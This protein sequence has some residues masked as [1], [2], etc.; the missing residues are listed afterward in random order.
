MRTTAQPLSNPKCTCCAKSA[1]R[2]RGPRSFISALR[3]MLVGHA[4][5]PCFLPRALPPWLASVCPLVFP[6]CPTCMACAT[7]A[8]LLRPATSVTAS[9]II[10]S[11]PE[12]QLTSWQNPSVGA[13][14]VT[15]CGFIR[16]TS[17]P[18]SVGWNRSSVSP[19]R[20]GRTRNN[21][22]VPTLVSTSLAIS[23]VH[24]LFIS[25]LP[26][27]SNSLPS[28]F[29]GPGG[30]RLWVVWGFLFPLRFDSGG[31]CPGPNCLGRAC[32]GSAL[33]PQVTDPPGKGVLKGTMA[34]WGWFP[35]CR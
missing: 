5:M 20:R 19:S 18:N 1:Y 28:L 17:R 24:T 34:T 4:C 30:A 2:L 3:G 6:V 32:S 21:S 10:L 33:Q 31:F 22:L 35:P 15:C 29:Q 7:H 12:V 8:C 27:R 23:L 13:R 11:G 14:M 16:L 9:A 25:R 26:L